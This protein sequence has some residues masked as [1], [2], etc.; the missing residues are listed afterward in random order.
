M[1]SVGFMVLFAFIERKHINPILPF[2]L[3]KNP[4]I[5]II[6]CNLCYFCASSGVTYLFPQAMKE[7]EMDASFTGALTSLGLFINIFV[8]AFLPMV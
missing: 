1:L 4:V 8:S 2:Y 7:F 5:D 6:V 3:M